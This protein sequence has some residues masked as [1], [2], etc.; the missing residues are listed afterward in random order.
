MDG[1]RKILIVLL[2]ASGDVVRGL[3]LA[4]RIKKHSPGVELCWAVEPRS[5]S[6]VED[7]PAIDKVIV[8]D[9]PGGVRAFFGF[10][11]QLR[12]ERFDLVLDLQRHLKS[13]IASWSRSVR[14]AYHRIESRPSPRMTM[15]SSTCWVMT[16]G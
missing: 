1:A 11:R 4:L 6:L 2:G 13:G 8:F 9:R 3:S 12:S 14:S 5:Q 16:R 7:H 15:A 10:L